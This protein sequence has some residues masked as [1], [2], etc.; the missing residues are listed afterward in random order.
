MKKSQNNSYSE[1]ETIDNGVKVRKCFLNNKPVKCN[2]KKLL[3]LKNKFKSM[4]IFTRLLRNY[5]MP[6]NSKKSK[7][8]TKRKT[9]RRR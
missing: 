2:N 5:F 8:T 9:K 7:I 4:N 3:S 6:N 1:I